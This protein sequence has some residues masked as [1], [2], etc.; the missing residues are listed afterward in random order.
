MYLLDTA[1]AAPYNDF[2]GDVRVIRMLPNNN[3]VSSQLVGSDGNST[4]NYLLVDEMPVATS[5]YVG[6][7]TVGNRD[8]YELS[9]LPTSG[10]VYATQPV[11]WA[12]KTDVGA[13]SLKLLQRASGGTIVSSTAQSVTFGS[14]IWCYGDLRTT[15]PAG[16]ALTVANTNSQQVGVEVV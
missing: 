8:L 14:Y 3:G 16:A 11:V 5:D 13:R 9:D 1:G 6:S 15:D 12:T 4:D 10:L 2:L 7:L